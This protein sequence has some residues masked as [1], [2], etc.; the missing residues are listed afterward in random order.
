MDNT[1]KILAELNKINTNQAVMA[2][3]M[4]RIKSD[5]EKLFELIDT[6]F[7]TKEEMREVKSD[8]TQFVTKDEFEPIKRLAYGAVSFILLAVLGVIITS[9]L[10]NK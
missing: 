4:S 9:A 10:P 6:R 7:A 5:V 1:E 8:M 3:D 2:N